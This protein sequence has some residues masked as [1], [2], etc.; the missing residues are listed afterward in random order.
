MQNFPKFDSKW[1]KFDE[2]NGF[3]G[4][5]IS[6]KSE[7]ILRLRRAPPFEISMHASGVRAQLLDKNLEGGGAKLLI[8]GEKNDARPGREK[9]SALQKKMDVFLL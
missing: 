2:K 4:G 5:R 1:P 9:F 6:K 7:K 3:R 8:T